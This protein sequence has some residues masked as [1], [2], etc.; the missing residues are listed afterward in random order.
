MLEL[1]ADG[2]YAVARCKISMLLVV[3][4]SRLSGTDDGRAVRLSRQTCTRNTFREGIDIQRRI[5]LL[6]KEVPVK[7]IEYKGETEGIGMIFNRANLHF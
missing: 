1:A 2:I 3:R 5:K 6:K 4:R 7:P